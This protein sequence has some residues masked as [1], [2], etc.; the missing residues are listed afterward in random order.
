MPNS[1]TTDDLDLDSMLRKQGNFKKK[2][3]EAAR[4]R[5]DPC[6]KVRVHLFIYKEYLKDDAA[7]YTAQALRS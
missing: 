2:D 3:F 5:K 6:Y 4:E 7:V 1:N